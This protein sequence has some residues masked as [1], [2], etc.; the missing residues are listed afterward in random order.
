MAKDIKTRIQLEGEK[1][2]RSALS[3]IN[4]NLKTLRS[5][6]QVLTTAYDD[7]GNAVKDYASQNDNLAKQIEQQKDKIAAI[8][9]M[10]RK[11]ADAYGEAD[12]QTQSYQQ[13]LNRAQAELNKMEAAVRQ[14]NAA[15]RDT[16]DSADDAAD[17]VDDVGDAAKD[18]EGGFSVMRGAMAD[19]VANGIQT[20]ISGCVDA[21]KS[22]AGLADET[23]EFR[24][25]MAKVDTAF[26]DAGLGADAAKQTYNDFY[27]VLGDEGQ[28][29]EAI[30]HVAK[31]A[32][33]QQDLTDWTTIATGVWG[34]FGDSLPIESLTEASNETIKV[35][36]VTGA[37]A[38]ALNWAGVSEDDFNA[39]L[40][41][42]RNESERQALVT[43]TLVG[44]YGD[45]A[46]EY[47][48]NAGSIMDAQRAQ[49]AWTQEMARAGQIIEP[50]TTKLTNMR[51]ELVRGLI[52][53]WEASDTGGGLGEQVK[54]F[55]ATLMGQVG[56]QIKVAAAASPGLL[57][58]G[59]S[60]VSA[61]AS[62]IAD[63]A[64]D[65]I[66]TAISG[67]LASI[68][69][70]I[71]SSVSLTE[72]GV[73]ICAG[74]TS[75]MLSSLPTIAASLPQIIDAI[76]TGILSLLATVIECGGTVLQSFGQGLIDTI[77]VLLQ[78]VPQIVT[79]VV[80]K[81]TSDLPK[82]VDTGVK[83]LSEFAKGIIGAIP[84]LVKQLPQIIVAIVGA[85]VSALPQIV[86]AGAKILASLIEGILD[87]G[88]SIKDAADEIID[89]IVDALAAGLDKIKDIGK[90]IV[91]G[92][93]EG[94]TGAAGW[95]GSKIKGFG[96]SIVGKF[97]ETFAIHSPAKRTMPIGRYIAEGIGAGW[98]DAISGVTRRMRISAGQI[99]G[100]ISSAV[101][102]KSGSGY[103]G[104]VDEL[105]RVRASVDRGQVITMDGKVV[106][107]R[108]TA[109]QRSNNRRKGPTPTFA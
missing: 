37:L 94:I 38:D 4:Q 93:W 80:A 24:T 36:A 79:N 48:A 101:S 59:L 77:P 92:I 42:C 70:I 88:A 32:K 3:T 41:S 87:I 84:D 63:Y 27:A 19:L 54:T 69:Q 22:I 82:I 68:P 86:V 49:A 44:L 1:E 81:I 51:T 62:G 47:T 34:T 6:M 52:D 78:E 58:A 90:R 46:Q 8:S 97:K 43:Q 106:T 12:K 75:G 99:A 16:G 67:L 57:E 13:Q 104:I 7:N 108:V 61:M 30:N 103:R 109:I 53:T 102:V 100:D 65:A 71:T 40:E 11:A 50:I 18:S 72:S 74:I 98:S 10:V 55:A 9:D 20:L 23:R 96:D 107:K 33:S 73:Q 85:I 45:A 21:V 64:P 76:V 2:Y 28:T 91:E 14:N 83:T 105:R 60:I 26:S 17:S 29:T 39:K 15:M 31:M 35:G 5:E 66:H 25:N 56:E 95:L 89:S